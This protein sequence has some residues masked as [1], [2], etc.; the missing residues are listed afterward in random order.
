MDRQHEKFVASY[1]KRPSGWK[2]HLDSFKATLKRYPTGK[3][4]ALMAYMDSGLKT[5]F[6]PRQTGYGNE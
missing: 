3:L 5:H 6:H 4:H 1:K 2:K